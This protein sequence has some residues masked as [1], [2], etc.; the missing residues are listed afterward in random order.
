M[1]DLRTA[2]DLAAMALKLLGEGELA[3]AEATARVSLLHV[4]LAQMSL[5]VLEGA[6]AV[7]PGI[8]YLR[9]WDEW[10]AATGL[11]L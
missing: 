1:E 2:R 3:K 10:A 9:V 11:D 6:A 8:K 5:A 7:P 4:E